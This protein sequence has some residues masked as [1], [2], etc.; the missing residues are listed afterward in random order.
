[1]HDPYDYTHPHDTLRSRPGFEVGHP[2]T[3]DN[4]CHYKRDK[5]REDGFE[6]FQDF[7][8]PDRDYVTRWWFRNLKVWHKFVPGIEAKGFTAIHHLKIT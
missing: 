3:A 6:L 5:M 4:G 8:H 2:L 1:M 7:Q